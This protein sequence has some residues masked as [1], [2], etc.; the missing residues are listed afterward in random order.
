MLVDGGQDERGQGK[1]GG[2]L[3]L[4][5]DQHFDGTG[6]NQ[7]GLG[8]GFDRARDFRDEE[9]PAVR[10]EG[11]KAVDV[12]NCRLMPSQGLLGEVGEVYRLP[13]NGDP[14]G[15]VREIV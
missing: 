9:R 5:S 15:D 13:G 12:Q 6:E 11:A 10:L 1:I 3:D 14:L 7:L 4:L 8:V 2:H